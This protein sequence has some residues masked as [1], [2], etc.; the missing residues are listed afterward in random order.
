MVANETGKSAKKPGGGLGIKLLAAMVIAFAA[1]FLPVT[2]TL[3]VGML[4]S[5][6]AFLADHSREKTRAVT[7]SLMNFVA[8]FPFLLDVA[9]APQIMDSAYA[10]ILNPLSIVIMYLGAV[11][12]YFLDWTMAGISN[13]I[14]TTRAKQRLDMIAR[15]QKELVRRWGPE[16]T[17]EIPVDQDGF[18]LHQIQD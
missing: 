7:V 14:M 12:G 2:V 8:C 15:R 11:M 10:V 5:I 6:A 13:V 3:V 17:G 9:L 4:P 16:V 1:A 18:P